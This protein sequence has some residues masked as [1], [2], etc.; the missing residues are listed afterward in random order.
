MNFL[1]TESSAS[2]GQSENQSIV[3]QFTREGKLRI[4]F[5][6]ESPIGENHKI[7]CRFLVHL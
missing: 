4:L 3:H 5:L 6:N 1:A 2:S 7:I